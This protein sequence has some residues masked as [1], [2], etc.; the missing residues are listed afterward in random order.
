[1][2]ARFGILGA[3]L[4]VS[5]DANDRKDDDRRGF[6]GHVRAAESHNPPLVG[7]LDNGTH[8]GGPAVVLCLPGQRTPCP[9]ARASALQQLSRMQG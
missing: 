4:V 1:M 8:L 7:E 3:R 9:D 2:S 6:V 5:L